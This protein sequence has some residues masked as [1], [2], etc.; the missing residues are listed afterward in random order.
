MHRLRVTLLFLLTCAGLAAVPGAAEARTG[1]CLTPA[2]PSTCTVWTG[3]VTFIGDGDTVYVDLDNDG[4]RSSKAIRITAINAMEQSVYAETA[5][6]RR[7]ECHALE[8][9][10]RLERLIRRSR[11]RVRL[12]A[13]DPGSR[14]RNR[15]RRAVAVKL[16]GRWRDV[17]RRMISEGHALWLPTRGEYA[18]NKDYSVLAQRAA[19]RQVGVWNPQYCGAG[20]SETSP[21]S[22][23]VNSDA[24]GSDQDFVNGEWIKIRNNDPALEVPLGG[25]WVR[26]S[27]VRRYTFPAWA[28]LQPGETM[29]VRM[30]EGP[31]TWTEQFWGLSWPPFENATDGEDALGDGAFLFDPQGDM[32]AWMLYPCRVNCADPNQGAIEISAKTR[33]REHIL[34]RNISAAAVDLASYRLSAPPFSYAFPGDSVLNPGEVMRIDITG[35]PE[36]DTR[37]RKSWG[38]TGAILR[39]NGDTVRLSTFTEI[40]IACFAFGDR[41]C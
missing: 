30:G 4:S 12:A 6:Q 20:P 5:T 19:Q 28:T 8:A 14:S 7:G 40:A 24:D 41:T 17:G 29:T 9:T 21:L 25:W 2:V 36:V 31:N 37:L 23:W 38:E 16:R 1:S 11:G 39:N 34:L 35:D 10:G 15:L 33:G 22:L 26:D 18:W 32:R 13:L 27:Q 3:R